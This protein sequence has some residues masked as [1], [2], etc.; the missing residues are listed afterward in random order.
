MIAQAIRRLCDYGG[1]IRPLESQQAATGVNVKDTPDRSQAPRQR[2]VCPGRTRPM[3]NP[4][5]G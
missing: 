3:G 2:T 1:Q 5:M 4:E